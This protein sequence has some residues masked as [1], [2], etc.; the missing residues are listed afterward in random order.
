MPVELGR[1][2]VV[3]VPE[4]E[5]AADERRTARDQHRVGRHQRIARP[6]GDPGGLLGETPALRQFAERRRGVGV[7]PQRVLANGVGQEFEGQHPIEPAPRL[8]QEPAEP[9]EVHPGRQPGADELPHRIAETELQCGAQ[10]V[11]L[12]AHLREQLDLVGAAPFPA[13]A[14][15]Q[16]PEV[17]EVPAAEPPLVARLLQQPEPVVADRVEHAEPGHA[18]DLVPYQHGLVDQATKQPQQRR[19]GNPLVGAHRGRRP[20]R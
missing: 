1:P 4:F 7:D 13:D 10:V 17:V 8:A 5:L 15:D 9:V 2:L 3:R 18:A 16:L 6:V 19:C 14:V 20:R 11:V 12:T